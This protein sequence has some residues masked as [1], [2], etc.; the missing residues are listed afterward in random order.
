M[1]IHCALYCGTVRRTPIIGRLH[2]TCD[3]AEHRTVPQLPDVTW[4]ESA[5]DAVSD[6]D[7]LVIVTE[8]NEFRALDLHAAKERM[9]GSVLVDLRN[10]FQPDAAE[11]AGFRYSGIGR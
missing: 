10:M 8:W 1:K 11:A 3:S 7:V 6:A 9:R 4:C 2:D 5:L